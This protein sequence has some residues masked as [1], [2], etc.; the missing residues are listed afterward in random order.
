MSAAQGAIALVSR[1]AVDVA[2]VDRRLGMVEVVAEILDDGVVTVDLDI[3]EPELTVLSYLCDRDGERGCSHVLAAI[4]TV[5]SSHHASAPPAAPWQ[6]ALDAM[7]PT[8]DLGDDREVALFVAH[9]DPRAGRNAWV[10]GDRRQPFLG[11]R[12]AIRG[13]RG[14]WIRGPIT[15]GSLTR[16]TSAPER[17]L[18][19]LHGLY[20]AGSGTSY[21]YEPEW[22]PLDAFSA[23]GLLPLLT[24]IVQAGVE[25]VAP[26][27]QQ[28]PLRL[29]SEPAATRISA[30]RHRDRLRVRAQLLIDGAVADARSLH[31][32]GTPVVAVAEIRE[33]GLAGEQ[34]TL[35]PLDRP[36]EPSLWKLLRTTDSVSVDDAGRARFEAD[37]LPRLR[38]LAPVVSPDGSYDVP[39]APELTLSLAVTATGDQV[40]TTWSWFGHAPGTRPDPDEQREILDRVRAAVVDRPDL[41]YG[42]HGDD[43]PLDRALAG[44]DAAMF[45]G[46]VLPHLRGLER[47]EIVESDGVPDYRLTASGPQVS[48][49]ANRDNDWFDLSVQVEV[50]GEHVEFARVFRALAEG[51]PIFLLSDG[52]YFSLEG[53]EFDRLRAIIA[54]AKALNERPVERLRI[55]RYQVDLWTELVEL[56]IVAA[57]EEEWLA[58][59]RSL[60]EVDAL[61]QVPAPP[62]LKAQLRPYQES[63][64]AWL[65]FLRRHGLGG[66]LGDDMGL[67]KTLQAIGMMEIARSEDPQM[68][69]FLVVAPTSVVGNW[70]RECARFAP[71][72]RVVAIDATARR[73]GMPLDEAVL[74]AHVVVTSYTLVRLEEEAYQALSWSGLILDEAQMV[75]NHR[76]RGYRSVR[77][78]DAPMKLA[79]TG[80][81]LE[82]NLLELWA[83][84]SLTCP[85]LLGGETHFTEVY[86]TPIEKDHEHGQLDRLQRRLRPFL[87]RRR[88]EEVAADLP[89]KQE[90]VMELTLHPHHR[91]LYDLRLQRERQKILG[92]L[93]DPETNKFQ[94]FRSLTLLRQLALDAALVEGAEPPD[95][96]GASAATGAAPPSA[97][98]ET[99]TELL[100]EAAA[101]GHRVLVFSQFTRFLGKARDLAERAGVTTAYLDG[102]TR[103]RDAEIARFREGEVSAFFVS[104]KAGGFGLNLTEADYVV[105]LDPWWNPAT[106]AQAIDRTHR[107]GQTRSVMVYRLVSADTIEAKV[108]ALSARKAQLF[109]DVLDGG[110]ATELG[111]LTTDEIRGLVS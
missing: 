34:V 85:G 52:R 68:P 106:E 89:P 37:Y 81:P 62:G 54:E 38:A 18:A 74:G 58:Q 108:L 94:V 92:L 35:H 57:Q 98:L 7:L 77:L 99:L 44:A 101:E 107:I 48:V 93:E 22:L 41:V 40:H 1:D 5:L 65:T 71:E 33:A 4:L 47:V 20:T 39:A 104:L 28:R 8:A 14:A 91:R 2:Q 97:K 75:K 12:P 25:M 11:I 95:G 61:E 27:K 30:E 64:L 43:H 19:E 67:G 73:R 63:G 90:Q 16:G 110:D 79:I 88:K 80:T 96:E 72:L 87:L 3:G 26:G 55:S 31:A 6:R 103:R 17:L 84:A 42:N 105:L 82:N 109:A 66:I 86:R 9:V 78:I 36:V 83:L 23:R 69:P 70:V 15:W 24:E 50:D 49:S 29:V 51:E 53:P 102:R 10:Y 100:T 21:Y 60:S 13:A 32:V 59:V 46:Q 76:A 111:I 56:G 45:V